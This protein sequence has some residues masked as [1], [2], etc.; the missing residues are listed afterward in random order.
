MIIKKIYVV[1]TLSMLTF[2]TQASEYV[3]YSPEVNTGGDIGSDGSW[4]IVDDCAASHSFL[5]QE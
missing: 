1:L 5:E 4:Q 3:L 2:L